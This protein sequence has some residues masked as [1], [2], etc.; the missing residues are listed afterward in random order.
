M[1][2]G[3]STVSRNGG[4]Y[5]WWRGLEPG[6]TP[7]LAA[8]V[9]QPVFWQAASIGLGKLDPKIWPAHLGFE[10]IRGIGEYERRYR[11][12]LEIMMALAGL[13]L[14][15]A[16]T[17]VALLIL[18]R[19]AAREREFA[20][21]LAAGAGARRIFAQLL[22]ESV[23]LV[24]VGAG[25]GWVLAIGATRAL[26][27]W[28]RINSGLAP[29]RLVLLFTLGIASAVALAVS[30][31]PFRQTMRLRVDEVLKSASQNMS[32]SRSRVRSGNA[33]I[34]LQIAM[35][36]TLLVAA[37]LTVRT[38]ANYEDQNVGMKAGQLL[39]FDVNPQGLNGNVQA[40]SFYNRLLEQIR[41]APGVEAASMTQLRLGSGWLHSGGITL[42][43]RD[44]RKS[45]G[46]RAEIYQNSVGPDFFHTLGVPVLQGREI[47]GSD[48]PGSTPVVVVNEDFAR[49]FLHGDPL[50]HKIDS[51]LEIVGVVK[52]SKYRSVTE[53]KMPTIYYAFAQMGM[54]GQVTVEVRS[55]R[56]PMALLPEIR[57]LVQQFDPDL[58]LQSPMTQAEQFQQS[59][60]RPI[61][62]ARLAM[63]FGA[64]AVALVATGLYG[65]L[66][67]RLQR[68]RGEIG[69]RMALGALREQ[70]LW[71][72][73]RESLLIA[74]VGFALGL[75]LALV[76]A[77]LLRS[78]LYRMSAADPKSFAAALAITLLLAVGAA[79]LPARSA[80]RVDPI[81]AL[82]CE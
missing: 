53:G 69:I 57:R 10:P 6:M 7:E 45:T 42:D 80:A 27:A 31:G 35:C 19:N 26:A 12:P 30:L 71:A 32:Q 8:Q 58:P 64:L 40:W 23:L 34:A 5:Q 11:T 61:L 65:T 49:E 18:A 44:L 3:T 2:T 74:M 51:G 77:H 73:V 37:G 62:F 29:D 79:Y 20:V 16:C 60:L 14:L 54:T 13:V 59:Y 21:R 81:K 41:D 82:R 4:R 52:D 38:L 66:A 39:I 22:T 1:I 76:T 70:V 28:A 67:Y 78:Q 25:L 17:N 47:S 75:P 72:V 43:G 56:D 50:G 9:V 36:F 15:I 55:A 24:G 63:G 33:A 48:V 68:R 46:E